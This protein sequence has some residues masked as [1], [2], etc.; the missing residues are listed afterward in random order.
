MIFVIFAGMIINYRYALELSTSQE[1][2]A[3]A[4]PIGLGGLVKIKLLRACDH[5]FPEFNSHDNSLS[6]SGKT[7][8]AFG[9]L[10]VAVVTKFVA[11]EKS[12]KSK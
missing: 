5:S 8:S 6:E 9:C 7:K 2:V 4:S 10:S 12:S 1:R 3:C 11:P